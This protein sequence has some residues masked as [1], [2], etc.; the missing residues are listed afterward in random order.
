MHVV[1]A[2]DLCGG[3]D[4]FSGMINIEQK[5]CTEPGRLE[6]GFTLSPAPSSATETEKD[7]ELT[8]ESRQELLGRTLNQQLGCS[9][10]TSQEKP[11]KEAS[12]KTRLEILRIKSASP[13]LSFSAF[14]PMVPNLPQAPFL[15]TSSAQ[16]PDHPRGK[17]G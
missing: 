16:S 8:F 2:G 7:S 17:Q 6:E 1:S 5:D 13:G 14:L 11:S 4:P 9:G 3:S 10:N 12:N 15:F